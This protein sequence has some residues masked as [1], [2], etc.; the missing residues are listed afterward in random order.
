[1]DF[2]EIKQM[3]DIVREHELAEFELEREGFKIRIRKQTAARRLVALAAPVAPLRGHPA[4]SA[5]PRTC[6]AACAGPFRADRRRR[7]IGRARGREIADRRHVLS[8]AGARRAAVRRSRA[9]RSGRTRCSA[10]SK[11]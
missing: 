1:M 6:G 7:W 4:P 5:A 2:D 9:S 8:L 11:R 10:S 3:L